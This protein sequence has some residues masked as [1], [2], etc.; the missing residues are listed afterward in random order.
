MRLSAVTHCECVVA[1]L[2]QLG[3]ARRCGGDATGKEVGTVLEAG[4]RCGSRSLERWKGRQRLRRRQEAAARCLECKDTSGAK[5][6][7]RA[8]DCAGDAA[9]GSGAEGG[10]LARLLFLGHR[11]GMLTGPRGYDG[12]GLLL[13]SVHR[14]DTCGCRHRRCRRSGRAGKPRVGRFLS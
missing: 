6:D 7:D 12:I 14:N 5:P 10:G 8:A 2:A 3:C 13:T 11:G 1:E 9:S 4:C